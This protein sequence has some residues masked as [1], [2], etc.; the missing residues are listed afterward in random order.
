MQ[1]LAWL[2]R[3]GWPEVRVPVALPWDRLDL[4]PANAAVRALS[5]FAVL[6]AL[7]LLPG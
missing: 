1:A 7:E 4:G 6:Y 2:A 5:D 3:D